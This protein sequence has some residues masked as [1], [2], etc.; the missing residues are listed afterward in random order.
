M[1]GRLLCIFREREK[2]LLGVVIVV[3]L[4]FGESG[5]E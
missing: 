4:V 5:G 3:M 1:R 2:V